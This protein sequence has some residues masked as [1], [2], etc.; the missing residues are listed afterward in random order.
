MSANLHPQDLL[1]TLVAT[2]KTILPQLER[3]PALAGVPIE[4]VPFDSY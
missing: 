4:V 3:M 1:I 2:A